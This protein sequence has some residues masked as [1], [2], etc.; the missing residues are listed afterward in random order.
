MN[1]FNS[2]KSAVHQQF[3]NMSKGKLFKTDV[4]KDD[5]WDTYINSF[6]KDTNPIFR[7]R[8]EHDCQNCKRFIRE[9]GN[10]VGVVNNKL[11]SIWDITLDDF[12][13][14]VADTLSTFVKSRPIKDA[15]FHNEKNLGIDFNIE[16]LA[17]GKEIKWKHLH[18]ELPSNFVV[19]GDSINTLLSKTRANKE[20][21]KRGLE[22]ITLSS[23]NIVLELI[24]AGSVY[25]GEEFKLAIIKFKEAKKAFDLIPEEEKDNYCWTLSPSD[26]RI[27][28][29]AIGTLLTDVTDGVDLDEA[30]AKFG[31]KMY[32]Y[33]R[34][35]NPVV[36]K[37][38][39]DNAKK[40][41]DDLGL[42][43]SLGRRY[44]TVDDI[45]IN[46]VI[47]AD[48]DAK[49]AMDVFDEMAQEAPTNLKS[50]KKV[51]EVDIKTFIDTILPQ[52][53]SVELMVENRH[54][55]NMM[56]LI[57]PINANAKHMFKWDNN[58]S[59]AY[60]G[61]V[62][63]SMMKQRVK[64][65]GGNINAFTRFTIQWNDGDNNQNDFD[66]HCIE[67]NNN[68]I[69]YKSRG[70][71]HPSSGM[72][73]VDIT[74]PGNEVAV[75][76]II[77]T[78]PTK[79]PEG[80][81]KYLVHNYSHNGGMTGFTA[82]FEY[83]GQIH[84]YVYGKG[85]RINEKV[86]VLTMRFSKET[87]VEIIKSLP[88]NLSSKEVWGVSTHTFHKVSM[89]MNSPN[90]WDG[91]ETGNKHYFFI[92]EGCH[93]DGTAR[94]FFNEFLL[95]ELNEHRKVFEILGG[96]MKTSPSDNQLSGL[97][98]SSTKRNHVYCKLSGNFSRTIKINF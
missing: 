21:S 54:E 65:A 27:R 49:K 93:R 11:V 38:M 48:R 55:P 26:T 13:Q 74:H 91:N 60:K 34:P 98:F 81:Y 75:E 69:H 50:L 2:F 88:S 42:L 82:E 85:L 37:K 47:F 53:N 35:K 66:A 15:L 24:D 84:S 52:V 4:D 59:W 36:T 20:V 63:D 70:R 19:Y 96:K 62:A 29:T 97:G 17:N 41:V 67:P 92:L 33:K 83:D 64:S 80:E 18:F 23:I 44:A 39:T 46:N 56:S 32:G 10:I 45:T 86:P 31:S 22:E 7:E 30:V 8:A 6:P 58:F 90:H 5:L 94:G 87:G 72:L 3:S 71:V 68:L 43:E 77:H 61:E 28:N 57:A 78:D 51:E 89:I 73:D 16:K 25:R 79:M 14:E 12:Y 1:D 95:E 40:K 76:N 9:A